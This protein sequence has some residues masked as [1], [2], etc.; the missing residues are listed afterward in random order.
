MHPDTSTKYPDARPDRPAPPAPGSARKVTPPIIFAM[1]VNGYEP[2]FVLRDV[3]R[4]LDEGAD[5]RD[6]DE[7]G[8]G[9][10]YFAV[11]EDNPDVLRLLLEHG[12]DPNTVVDDGYT[13]YDFASM[14]YSCE[15][16]RYEW[17]GHL[18]EKD[19]LSE[20]SRLHAL[21]RLAVKYGL[22]R[23]ECLLVLREFGARRMNELH[24]QPPAAGDGG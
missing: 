18:T 3:Q 9:P 12:A 5:P 1:R 24:P 21:D 13:I 15:M 20:D 22:P 8:H 17:P 7:N 11:L 2:Q 14:D 19:L 23:P 16:V 10:L 4:A 6:T